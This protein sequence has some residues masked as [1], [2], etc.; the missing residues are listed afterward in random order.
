MYFLQK[1]R[2]PG[3]HNTLYILLNLNKHTVFLGGWGG[4]EMRLIHTH[5][6]THTGTRTQIGI[7]N[8]ESL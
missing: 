1:I 8:F 2:I 5:T 4:G 7:F 6:H 3:H